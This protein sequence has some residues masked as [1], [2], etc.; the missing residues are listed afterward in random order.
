MP[1]GR[2]TTGSAVE[3][4]FTFNDGDFQLVGSDFSDTIRGSDRN[5]DIEGRGGDDVI[6]GR[7]GVDL[8]RLDRSG[9]GAVVVDLQKGMA[10]GT[11]NG[12]A[13]SYTHL[14]HRTRAR[15]Q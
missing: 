3:D 15:L 11:W 8:L 12:T 6:D 9:V 14:E 1:A 2:R 7:G 5:D 4:R 10:R 13:F